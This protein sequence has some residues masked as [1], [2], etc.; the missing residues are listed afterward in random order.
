LECYKFYS[1]FYVIGDKENANVNIPQ[2]NQELK[3]SDKHSAQSHSSLNSYGSLNIVKDVPEFDSGRDYYQMYWKAFIE[4]QVLLEDLKKQSEERNDH[5]RSMIRLSASQCSLSETEE[6]KEHRKKH[7]RRCAKE[8]RKQDICPY[9]DCGK[10]Y[11]SEG[12]LNLHMKLKH[13]G[14]NKTDREK[15]AKNIVLN[16]TNNKPF[17]TICLNLPPGAILEEA[18]KLNIDLSLQQ[19]A[20]LEEKVINS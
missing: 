15:L 2:G 1:N 7:I 9:G 16:F 12:S 13:G 17:P 11:G 8:I 3:E 19:I 18:R 6:R 4:N 5:Y 10:Y 20:M 14:G